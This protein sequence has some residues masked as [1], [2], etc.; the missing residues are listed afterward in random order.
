M[1][2]IKTTLLLALLAMVLRTGLF[3]AGVEVAPFK[4]IPAHLLL[5]VL[6]VY[7][8]GHVLL[9]RDPSRGFGELLRVGFQSALLYAFLLSLFI[10]V[11]YKTMDNTAFSTYNEK[12]IQ[13]FVAQ[14]HP[15]ALA[16]EKVGSMY[17]AGS[18]AVI[19]FFGLFMAG[20][21]N[22]MVFGVV[23]HKLLRR[24]RSGWRMRRMA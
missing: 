5:I 18:Y 19:S 1:S 8:S 17:N 2:G 16:R 12:L 21:L 24:F 3:F 20:A 13:G 15:E 22:A 4:F 6:A 10:W 7:F 9:N 23:H 14:G 11:Y